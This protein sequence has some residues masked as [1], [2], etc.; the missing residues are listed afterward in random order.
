MSR[1]LHRVDKVKNYRMR[2]DPELYEFFENRGLE[3]N[4]YRDKD[5][6]IGLIYVDHIVLNELKK[7][8]E[9]RKKLDV[10]RLEEIY[11]KIKEDFD[12]AETNSVNYIVW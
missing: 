9:E 4:L 3:N 7:Y 2:F 6:Y 8:I 5:G 12:K 11:N 1:C 10:S